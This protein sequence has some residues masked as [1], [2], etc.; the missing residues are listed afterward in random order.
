MNFYSNPDG[1]ANHTISN[2]SVVNCDTIKTKKS[3]MRIAFGSI[4]RLDIPSLFQAQ[5]KRHKHIA[6]FSSYD[7]LAQVQDSFN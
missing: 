1:P 2:I 5:L 3:S 6:T 7:L 4:V